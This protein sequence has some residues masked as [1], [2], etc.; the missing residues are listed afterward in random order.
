MAKAASSLAAIACALGS[1]IIS[2]QAFAQ[3]AAAVVAAP[4]F[5]VRTILG[6]FAEELFIDQ[7]MA[8]AKLLA[9]GFQFSDPTISD[10]VAGLVN[11]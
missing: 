11:N 10:I 3:T 9:T 5:A 2:T 1:A 7:R 8:P 6:E 4:R